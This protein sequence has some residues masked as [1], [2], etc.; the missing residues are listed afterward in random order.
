MEDISY[1]VK[2]Y[3]PISKREEIVYFH[4]EPHGDKYRVSENSFN[5][6]EHNFSGCQECH[7]CRAAAFEIMKNET[8]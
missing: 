8:Q 7:A 2:L 6:C 4:P 5:G 3:C 1:P